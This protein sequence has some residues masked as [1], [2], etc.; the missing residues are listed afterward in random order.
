MARPPPRT[1]TAPWTRWG[2]ERIQQVM[3]NQRDAYA[4]L[5]NQVLFHVNRLVLAR[6]GSREAAGLLA[7]FPAAFEIIPGTGRP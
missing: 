4:S 5:N 3:R 1:M 2:N 6:P 7:D